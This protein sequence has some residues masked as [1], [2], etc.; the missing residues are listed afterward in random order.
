MSSNASSAFLMYDNVDVVT[1]GSDSER[2]TSCCWD[3]DGLISVNEFARALPELLREQKVRTRSA[4]ERERTERARGTAD[5][6]V[7]SLFARLDLSPEVWKKYAMFDPSRKYTRNLISTDDETYTLLLLCW[8]EG[9]FSPIHD[10]PCD[11]CWL[12][13]CQGEIQETRYEVNEESDSLDMISDE[14]FSDSHP[15]FIQ[16]SMG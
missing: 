11:G 8:N 16:D 13:V 2:S 12:R 9:K 1:D 4:R 5:D 14:S 10:H 3:G 7:Q 15:A 6:P